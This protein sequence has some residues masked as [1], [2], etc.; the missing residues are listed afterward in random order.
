MFN[1]VSLSPYTGLVTRTLTLLRHLTRTDVAVRID[2]LARLVRLI[3]RHLTAYDLVKFHHRGA[4]YPDAL[5]LADLW[6]KL[7]EV[8]H[9]SPE[10][11]FPS[12]DG[13]VRRRRRALRHA[14]LLQL[15]YAGHPVP[16]YPTSIGENA[17]VM[18]PPFDRLPEEQIHAPQRRTRRL[19]DNPLPSE[20][21]LWSLFDDL[22][23]PLELREL[24]IA[25]FLNRPFGIGKS[26]G[27]P[28]RTPMFSHLLFSRSVAQR[29]LHSLTRAEK[30]PI[31]AARID[32]WMK[33]VESL[34]IDG[35]PLTDAGPPPRPGVVSLHDALLSADD[36]IMLRT[37]KSSLA[38]L[39]AAFDWTPVNLAPTRDFR[40]L[41][42]NGDA[43]IA[44]A[45]DGNPLCRIR[46][47]L[48][49][50]HISLGGVE[51]PRAGLEVSSSGNNEPVVIRAA[52]D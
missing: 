19:F 24:G 40:L 45:H 43:V 22:D 32:A 7:A 15:E 2:F 21:A 1:G 11:F 18:P 17:R 44:Y 27:D 16:D 10:Y 52:I 9:K 31:G 35:H 20:P 34:L 50:G 12:A 39:Q 29:R 13:R 8:Y 48:A 41:A 37:T 42:P 36:W 5:L 26:P 28:D 51:L 38:E 6:H 30:S 33:G 49:L 14:L 25:L 47:N 23:D 4:N 46:P 3:D